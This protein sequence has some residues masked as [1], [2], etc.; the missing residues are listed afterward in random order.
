MKSKVL[1]VL[2]VL[3]MLGAGVVYGAA[4]KCKPCKGKGQVTVKC[5]N[6]NG[7]GSW[8]ETRNLSATERV[9][10]GTL[11]SSE[12]VK[13]TCSLCGGSKKETKVCTECKGWGDHPYHPDYKPGMGF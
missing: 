6:C 5:S 11:K 13:I 10:K 12:K 8:T 4:S 7:K 9:A 1:A 3:T 2:V